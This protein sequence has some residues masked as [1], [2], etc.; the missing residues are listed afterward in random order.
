MPKLKTHKGAKTRFHV[1]GTGKLMR[2]KGMKSH[3]RR[4]KS[5]RVKSLFDEMIPVSP[6]D[7][8]RISR[9]IPYGA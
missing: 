7:R 5:Y 6:V 8:K 3:L 1:T 4:K 2:T 9:L